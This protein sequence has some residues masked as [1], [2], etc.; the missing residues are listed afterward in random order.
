[1]GYKIG[2]NY[3]NNPYVPEGDLAKVSKSVT[4]LSNTTNMYEIYFLFIIVLKFSIDLL[5]LLI[6]FMQKEHL[7]IGMSVKEWKKESFQKVDRI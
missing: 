1:M 5:L 3:S 2:I 6:K 4:M 7:Y